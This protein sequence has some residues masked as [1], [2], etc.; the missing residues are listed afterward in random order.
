MQKTRIRHPHRASRHRFHHHSSVPTC[1]YGGG[2]DH[3]LPR[4]LGLLRSA[5][6]DVSSVSRPARPWW[7]LIDTRSRSGISAQPGR[8]PIPSVD[9]HRL[10]VDAHGRI[11]GVDVARCVAI[12]WMFVAHVGPDPREGGWATV[13]WAGTGREAALFAILAGV[14]LTLSYGYPPRPP[15]RGDRLGHVAPRIVSRVLF[16]AAVLMSVGLALASL[17]S[18]I[19]V[20]LPSFALYFVVA[21]PALWARTR[22]LC[23]VALGWALAAPPVSMALRG[24]LDLYW[25]GYRVPD[26]GDLGDP[27]D[28]A[29]ALFLC[30]NYPVITWMPFV[31]AGVLLGRLDLTRLRTMRLL[32]LAGALAAFLGYGC[33]W[34]AVEVFGG[35]ERMR[36]SVDRIRPGSSISEPLAGFRGAVPTDDVSWLLVAEGHTGTSFEIVGA[37]GVGSAV[38]GL[39]LLLC[40]LP[41]AR[42]WTGAPAAMGAMSL[43]VYAAHLIAA[44]SPWTRGPGSWTRLAAFT[45]V[46]LALAW[47]W[48]R[49]V[50]R[51]PLEWLMGLPATARRAGDR[52]PAKP[53]PTRDARH[54]SGPAS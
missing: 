52:A 45:L 15:I 29:A 17:D 8:Q 33:S 23:L 13:L 24:S 38:L 28:M 53:D 41:G 14:S 35:R 11:S 30:G 16:R 54:P 10:D 49:Y 51:G 48:R 5:P 21:V 43:S 27:G 4:L 18:G 26:L 12:V 19:A 39:C 1:R 7:F 47:L 42:R 25:V 2:G 31:L 34:L 9:A 36:L 44:W 32:S 3:G 6:A 46:G 40:R 50:G 37:L 20:I 22:T